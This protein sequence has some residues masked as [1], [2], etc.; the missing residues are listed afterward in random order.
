MPSG[1]PSWHVISSFILLFTCLQ[2]TD[3]E[4]DMHFSFHADKLSN[5]QFFYK[6]PC[7]YFDYDCNY[8]DK[9]RYD[10]GPNGSV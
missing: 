5:V 9:D 10:S 7:V 4:D 2:N 1:L 3:A 8:Y 6:D